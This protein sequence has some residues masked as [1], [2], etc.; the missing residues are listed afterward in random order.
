[1]YISDSLTSM[2]YDLAVQD[3]HNPSGKFASA[4]VVDMFERLVPFFGFSRCTA[5]GCHLQRNAIGGKARKMREHKP[6]APKESRS[7]QR[8]GRI[9][10]S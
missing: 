2:E 9:K 10:N 6:G 8:R 4:A 5:C 3:S 1:M 7:V